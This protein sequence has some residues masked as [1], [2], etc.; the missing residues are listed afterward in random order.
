MKIAIALA[1]VL[2][3]SNAY[4]AD[5]VTNARGKVA[6]ADNGKAVGYNPNTGT[7]VKSTKNDAGVTTIQSSKSG[8]AKTKNGKGVYTSPSGTKCVKTANNAGCK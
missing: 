4:A 3:A 2:F 5:C 8:T 6:C 7:A 1:C